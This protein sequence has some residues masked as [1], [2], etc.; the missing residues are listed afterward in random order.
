MNKHENKLEWVKQV[1]KE[2]INQ[3]HACAMGIFLAIAI[4]MIKEL[5]EEKV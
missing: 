4:E 5:L 3:E 1:E 2:L